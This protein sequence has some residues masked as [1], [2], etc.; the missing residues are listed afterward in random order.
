M[1]NKS[2]VITE[3]EE[4]DIDKICHKLLKEPEER[5]LQA[6]YD[7]Y[8]KV[9]D[10]EPITSLKDITDDTERAEFQ[11]MVIKVYAEEYNIR[12]QDLIAYILKKAS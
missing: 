3:N 2:S 5:L 8:L 12:E 6:A 7:E 9:E 1:L 4:I 10:T 11:A